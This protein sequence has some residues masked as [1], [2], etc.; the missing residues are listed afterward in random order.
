VR[1][2]GARA[3]AGAGA[4]VSAAALLLGRGGD[5]ATP[6]NTASPATSVSGPTPT[7]TVT[8]NTR[9]PE[10][11][12]PQP[13]D[14]YRLAKDPEGFTIAVPNGFTRQ[15]EG[16]RV[17][18]VSPG[19]T[20]RIGIKES[21]RERGGP[22]AAQR[23]A[24]AEGPRTH[25]GYRDGEITETTRNGRPASLLEFTWDGFAEPA[26]ER[27]TYDLC[28]EEGGRMYDVWVSGPVEEAEQVRKYFDTVVD[29]FVR[30]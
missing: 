28:W 10:P 26:G 3:G 5:G 7:V 14:G 29:T 17:Y 12:T 20:Y 2:A 8:R 18:Y 19:G 15:T 16:P 6:A 9:T 25:P 1:I 30:R 11:S 13:P 23:R 22:L 27:H 4:G 21:D 24:D